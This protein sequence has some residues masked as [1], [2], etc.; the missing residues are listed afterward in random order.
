MFTSNLSPM[1]TLL[2]I[3]SGILGIAIWIWNVTKWFRKQAKNTQDTAKLGEKLAEQ[4]LNKATNPTRRAEIHAFILFNNVKMESNHTRYII[5]CWIIGA[6]LTIAFYLLINLIIR[7]I[8][9]W[10]LTW[11]HL[12]VCA[13][14][15]VLVV[16]YGLLVFFVF[17][18]RRM[19]RGWQD[20]T[21][22]ILKDRAF[23]HL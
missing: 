13:L 17:R 7:T 12:L 11:F 21:G 16:S 9:I 2:G 22:S 14:Y 23:S 6:S 19:Q 20:K 1:A 10:C 18:L 8:A 3:L 5:S 15:I 4:L